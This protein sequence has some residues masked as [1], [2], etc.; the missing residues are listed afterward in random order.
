MRSRRRDSIRSLRIFVKPTGP[1]GKNGSASG[2][3][4]YR[5]LEKAAGLDRPCHHFVRKTRLR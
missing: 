2:E 1:N 3:L 4:S 5:G